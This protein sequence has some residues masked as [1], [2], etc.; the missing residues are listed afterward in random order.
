MRRRRFMGN[1]RGLRKSMD[2]PFFLERPDRPKARTEAVN[3]GRESQ[4]DTT[5]LGRRPTLDQP[6]RLRRVAQRGAGGRPEPGGSRRSSR[7]R[8]QCDG[9]KD[10]RPKSLTASGRGSNK[11]RTSPAQLRASPSNKKFQGEKR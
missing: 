9:Q 11:R 4:T 1:N 5:L 7:Y 3:W 10:G 8:R 6:S 2:R